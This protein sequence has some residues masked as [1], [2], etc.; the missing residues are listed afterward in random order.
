MRLLVGAGYFLDLSDDR[1]VRRHDILS[2][3]G[4]RV[5]HIQN[6]VRRLL[7][8]LVGLIFRDFL[9]QDDVLLIYRRDKILGLGSK[10]SCAPSPVRCHPSHACVS[11]DKYHASHIRLNM[12]LLR[13][14]VDIH[15]KQVV[16]KQV[17]D[18][19]ILI[20]PLLVSDQKIL[21]LEALR[22][23]PTI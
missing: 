6:G 20:K 15:Q 7:K 22:A 23:L 18:K 8:I 1:T 9:Y 16:Q 17:L 14:V 3:I 2:V 5:Q 10:Q 21:D 11:I 12:E 4:F 19:V 13:A